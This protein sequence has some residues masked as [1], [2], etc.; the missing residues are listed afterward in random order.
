MA[1]KVR[2]TPLTAAQWRQ[3]F[4]SLGLTVDPNYK[5]PRPHHLSKRRRRDLDEITFSKPNTNKTDNEK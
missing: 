3:K 4:V 5:A 2:R 1:E